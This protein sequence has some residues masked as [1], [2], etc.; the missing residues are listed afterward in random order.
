MTKR[1]SG[2][3]AVSGWVGFLA[4]VAFPE[5]LPAK[6][7]L[8]EITIQG[9][10]MVEIYNP[11][12]G[13][14]DPN[15]WTIQEG[16][17]SWVIVGAD[18]M[19]PGE[20][21]VIQLPGDVF[22][23]QGGY[24]ELFDAAPEDGA[25]CGQFGSA[26]LPP[27]GGFPF[28][29]G[30]PVTLARAP[31]ASVYSGTAPTPTPATDGDIWTIDVTSTLG[32]ANDA[33]TPALGMS[34][35]LNELDTKPVGGS[36]LVELYNPFAVGVSLSGWFLCN[37]DAFFSLSGTVPGGGFLALTTDPGFDLEEDE[38]V[39]L[40]RNDEVRVDQIGLH[41]PPVV[42]GIP[43]LDFCQCF[44][45]YPDGSAPHN[46]Y[47]WCTSGGDDTLLRLLCTLGAAN[48]RIITCE[49]T[50]SPGPGPE[51]ESWGGTKA[52]YRE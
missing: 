51:A 24:I 19:L 48:Q 5:S 6:L 12:P 26:P 8:N 28:A 13:L 9:T 38:L 14:E 35:F 16:A 45:R 42:R 10:E 1:R 40:F 32:A 4:A 31:D 39:Y 41:Q 25:Y 29:G 2:L 47:D 21:Q 44:A 18:I 15:G 52:K 3:R 49:T 33:P 23:D 30:T 43:T 50:S 34:I 17:D 11:G 20:Y 46:G 36:D 7:L 27:G 37:G 22:G